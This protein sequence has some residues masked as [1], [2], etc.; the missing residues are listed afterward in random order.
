[1]NNPAQGAGYRITIHHG[2]ATSG[3]EATEQTE[4]HPGKREWIRKDSSARNRQKSQI[5][6]S[7]I[8]SS[9]PWDLTSLA[10]TPALNVIWDL[11]AA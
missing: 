11:I 6:F 8:H 5:V 3:S 10:Q 2:F 7:W 9:T 4:R 1:M